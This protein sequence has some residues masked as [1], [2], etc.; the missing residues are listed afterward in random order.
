MVSTA[1]G[2]P[3]QMQSE[4]DMWR[5][6]VEAISQSHPGV[7]HGPPFGMPASRAAR[8]FSGRRQIIST[9]FCKDKE[10]SLMQH[11]ILKL[12]VGAVA[13]KRG[14]FVK[15]LKSC[16]SCLFAEPSGCTEAPEQWTVPQG[17]CYDKSLSQKTTGGKSG[18]P[19]DSLQSNPNNMATPR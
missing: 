16:N 11:D 5:F 15:D 6:A 2:Q 3:G 7:V 9:P 8:V 17:V 18:F 10:E 13:F 19:L 1:D 4:H 12:E 14:G